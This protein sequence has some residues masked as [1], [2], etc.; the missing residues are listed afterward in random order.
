[1]SGLDSDP[2]V[3]DDSDGSTIL[4]QVVACVLFYWLILL[5]K[6]ID[7][8][9]IYQSASRW[10]QQQL[11]SRLENSRFEANLLLPF[12]TAFSLADG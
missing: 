7:V 6:S 4:A 3:V 5:Q 11:L 12:N 2:I 9:P 1:M 10:P 8:S